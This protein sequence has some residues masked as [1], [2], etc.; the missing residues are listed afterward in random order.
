MK[1]HT[2]IAIAAAVAVIGIGALGSAVVAQGQQRGY[3]PGYGQGYGQGYG[4]HRTNMMG[5]MQGRGMYGPGMQGQGMP[6]PG[7]MG[8]MGNRFQMMEKR[9]ELHDLNGDG[10]VSQAEIDQFRQDR[11]KTYDENK[12]GKLELSEFEKL[13]LNSKRDRMVD[14]FQAFDDDGDGSVTEDEFRSPMGRMITRHD[15]N[16]DGK[17][18]LNEMTQHPRGWGPGRYYNDDDANK[19]NKD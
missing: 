5:G 10:A 9:F 8:N 11:L 14:R 6:G 7:M 12:N 13:W 17:V 19:P 4:M 16:G 15:R 2:K 18:T 3:G 1:R